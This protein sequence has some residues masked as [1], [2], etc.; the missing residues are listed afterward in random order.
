MPAENSSTTPEGSY[1]L[2]SGMYFS[3]SLARYPR[4][5]MSMSTVSSMPGLCTLTTTSWPETVTALWTCAMEAAAIGVS[6]MDEKTLVDRTA[7]LL[8]DNLYGVLEG[9]GFHRVLELQK[10]HYELV[11]HDVRPA[12][13]VSG[14]TL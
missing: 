9:E 10:L 14:R 4:R 1:I 2:L 11:R 7:E 5:A 8:F 6:S 12:S 13:R 3:M